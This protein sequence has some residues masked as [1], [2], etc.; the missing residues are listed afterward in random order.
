MTERRMPVHLAVLVGAS[1]AAY[2]ISLAGMTAFQSAADQ[3]VIEERTPRADSA[4]RLAASHDRLQA[5]I[6][7]SAAVYSGSAARFD[8]VAA[9]ITSLD[10]SLDAYAGRMARVTGAARALPGHVSLPAVSRGSA[11]R[12]KPATS[13]STG[14]SGAP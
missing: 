5:E 3:A 13:A 8:E 2:A 4:D 6:D 1:T 7:R 14:A 11:A 12:S 9:G 10:G